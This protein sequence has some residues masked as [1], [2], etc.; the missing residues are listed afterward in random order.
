MGIAPRTVQHFE[1][2]MRLAIDVRVAQGSAGCAAT[3]GARLRVAPTH[4]LCTGCATRDPVCSLSQSFLC[5]LRCRCISA[6][7]LSAG[8]AMSDGHLRHDATA[9]SRRRLPHVSAAAVARHSPLSRRTA[10]CPAETRR[11]YWPAPASCTSSSESACTPACFRCCSV[12]SSL[13]A[14]ML[15]S[16]TPPA[17]QCSTAVLVRGSAGVAARWRWL[18]Q[19]AQSTAKWWIV[20]SR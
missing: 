5:S 13:M 12:H 15:S 8:S 16:E 18:P 20:C 2:R 14:V 3:F 6:A 1:Q 9:A 7:N 17:V 19:P 10:G 4:R 11:G